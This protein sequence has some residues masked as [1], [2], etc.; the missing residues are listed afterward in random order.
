MLEIILAASL[1]CVN[2]ET[3][4]PQMRASIVQTVEIMPIDVPGHTFVWEFPAKV[5]LAVNVNKSGCIVGQRWMT[6]KEA[7]ELFRAMVGGV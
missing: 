5:Y 3:M 2:I 4:P 7:E 1:P 6:H